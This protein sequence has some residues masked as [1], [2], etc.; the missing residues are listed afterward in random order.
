MANKNHKDEVKASGSKKMLPVVAAAV[1]LVCAVIYIFTNGNEP[2]DR[3]TAG[4]PDDTQTVITQGE[5]LVIPISEI[6]DEAS[7]F[8]ITVDGE[9]MEV[10]AVRAS[11]GSIRT[12]F[13]TCQSCYT[14]GAGFYRFEDGELVCNNCGFHFSP[15]QVEVTSGGCNPWPIF[16]EN[17]TVT[18]DSIS[19]SY[20]FLSASKE[21]FANWK[22]ALK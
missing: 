4:I 11:D 14:S 1:V 8:P 13:N 3:Q 12:A 5:S 16:A 17:K 20:D 6:T 10:L 9:D 21:I 2:I 22:T 15:D 19:I 7:F 18:D